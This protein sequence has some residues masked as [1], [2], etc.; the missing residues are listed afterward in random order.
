MKTSK[1]YKY[2]RL[3]IR[4]KS[5]CLYIRYMGVKDV[6]CST[7]ITSSTSG[8]QGIGSEDSMGSI[9]AAAFQLLLLLLSRAPLIADMS[10]LTDTESLNI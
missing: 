5:K 8:Y 6:R 4:N 7:T 1:N 3:D 2:V 10:I 9:I